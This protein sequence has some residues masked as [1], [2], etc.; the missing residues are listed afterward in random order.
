M[1]IFV[2]NIPFRSRKKDLEELFKQYGSVEKAYIIYDRATRRSKGYGFVEMPD[3][4]HAKEAMEKLNGYELNGKI[5]VVTEAVSKKKDTE[6][7]TEIK[8]DTT[9]EIET[10]SETETE[11]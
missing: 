7:E 4:N 11:F 1:L 10:K 9:I 3:E 8:T 2:A 6:Q 5:L